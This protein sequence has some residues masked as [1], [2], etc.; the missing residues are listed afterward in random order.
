MR[1]I[2]M[3]IAAAALIMACACTTSNDNPVVIPDDDSTVDEELSVGDTDSEGYTL[4]WIDE[5]D[6]ETLNE[7]NWTAELNGNGNGNSELEYY[8][9]ANV[10]VET[11]P[12]SGKDCLKITARRESYG[13]ASFTS[14]RINT[15]GK[16]EFTHGK[17]EACIMLPKTANG[18]WPAFWLLGADYYENSWPYCGEIDIVEMGNATGISHDLQETYM[19]GACHWG[20][21]IGSAYPNYAKN[22][23]APYSVQDG[24]F[25]LFTLIW[26]EDYIRMYLDR[27]IY[28]D[29]SPY[30]EMQITATDTDSGWDVGLYFHKDYFILLN[31]AVGGNF[32]GIHSPSGITALPEDG[33]EAYMY[34]DYVRVFQKI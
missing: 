21:Y 34:V 8:R 7:A 30:Y 2:V 14:G 29:V 32:T 6:G 18:L 5:F 15:S 25:H 20:Y 11:E 16:Y 24:E 12:E 28:P 26:D 3:I 33:S 19:N 1:S 23:N 9:A 17:V 27:N 10:S 22:S 31:L 4:M 13:W